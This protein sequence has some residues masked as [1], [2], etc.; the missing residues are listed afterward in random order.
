MEICMS[1]TVK[2]QLL[3]KC[4]DLDIPMVGFATADRWDKPLFE[5]WV[6]E[7][8]RPRAI[9]PETNTIIVIGLPVSLP[10]LETSPSIF[11][12]ELYRTVNALLDQYAYRIALSLTKG[13]NPSIAIPRDGYGSISIL[14]D[15]PLAFFS[16]RHA[17]LLAG[18]GNFGTNN[19]LLT[20]AFGPRVRFTSIFTSAEIEPD[21]IMERSLCIRCMRCVH[22]C[23]VK[24]LDGRAYPDGLTNKKNC[25]TRSEALFKRYISPCGLCIKV[26]PVGEDRKQ[27]GRENGEIYNEAD[28]AFDRLHRAWKHVRSYGG[29]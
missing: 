2:E 9:Y 23:P 17:A 21:P 12:H 18:L 25:A 28:P 7:E 1:G 6:P 15:R 8:F 13:G 29:H 5:P 16:H 24:A 4:G 10:V 14:K 3:K 27:F 26:C 11:Y 19:V 20:P 22:A